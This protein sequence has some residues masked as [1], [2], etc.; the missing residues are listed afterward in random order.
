MKT[1]LIESI[2]DI[3]VDTFNEGEGENI[4]FYTHKA[5]IEADNVGEAIEKYFADELFLSFDKKAAYIDEISFLN[6]SNMVDD[7]NTDPT[8]KQIE[9][10]KQGTQKLY[11]NNSVV[12]AYELVNVKIEF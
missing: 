4:N 7:N 6:Y 5:E 12:Y 1:F 2:H 9:N 11:V 10:W 8:E 3:Y